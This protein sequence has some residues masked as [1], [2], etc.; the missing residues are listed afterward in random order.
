MKASDS[1]TAATRST[2]LPLPEGQFKRFITV[3]HVVFIGGL[4]CS[5]F[6]HWRRTGIAWNWREMSLWL[7]VA[8]Q[9]GL[10]L[11]YFVFQLNPQ[12][13]P[14]LWAAY[15]LAAFSLWLGEWR[16]EPSFEWAVGA[17][18][19]Q[20]FGVLSPRSSIP[21]SGLV[22]VIYFGLKLGWDRLTTLAPWEWVMGLA[23]IASWSA[24]GLFIHRLVV[25]SSERARLI[26][27][28]EAA[29]RH[30]ELARQRDAELAALRERER[31]AR[32]LHDSL[33]HNLVTLTV[34]L[35]AGERLCSVDPPRAASLLTQMKQLTRSSTEELRRSLAGLRA[36]GL[37]DRS[38]QDALPILCAELSQRAGLKINCQIQDGTDQLP[39]TVSETLWRVAQEGLANTEKHAHAAEAW[40]RLEVKNG[41]SASRQ[42]ILNVADNGVG[43]STGADAVPGHYGLKGIRER[44]EGLGGTFELASNFPRGTTI[45]VRIPV[46]T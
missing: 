21:A 18:L 9:I 10:Y 40:I 32:D 33:G 5:L 26:Q 36:S 42:A 3:F 8:S 14:K 15:F 22:F 12:L 17:L 34:Q 16:L 11:R 45:E 41:A 24:L 23:V 39:P 13:S 2:A 46:V 27:E 44:V 37:G 43:M 30:V 29:R 6:F 31:L 19:G 38:L 4:L 20:M 7:L 1:A 28:L 25:T 35:E